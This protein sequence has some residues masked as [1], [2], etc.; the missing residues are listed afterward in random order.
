MVDK[1]CAAICAELQELSAN[2]TDHDMSSVAERLLSKADEGEEEVDDGDEDAGE[3][4][5]GEE[6]EGEEDEGEED[7]GEEDCGEEDEEAEYM[8]RGRG[9]N[10]PS[11]KRQRS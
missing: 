2:V 3:E 6:D 1:P 10:Y 4:D 7:E 9:F 8:S 5:S 11:A